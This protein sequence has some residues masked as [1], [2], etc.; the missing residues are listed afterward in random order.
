MM[1]GPP[2]YGLKLTARLPKY[3]GARSLAR[4][5]GF[6]LIEA[7]HDTNQANECYRV[8]PRCS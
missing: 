8:Y 6:T 4:A 3:L 2:N 7:T 1:S 5:L